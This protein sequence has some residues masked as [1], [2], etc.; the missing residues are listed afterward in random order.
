MS[1]DSDAE[2]QSWLEQAMDSAA[3]VTILLTVGHMKFESFWV[4]V[5]MKGA[6]WRWLLVAGQESV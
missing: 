5:D 3:G 2:L 4:V 6:R 1:P